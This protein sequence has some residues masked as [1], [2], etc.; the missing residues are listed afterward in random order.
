MER[1]RGRYIAPRIP[2]NSGSSSGLIV[3]LV[4]CL[5]SVLVVLG[6]YGAAEGSDNN[7]TGV[8]TLQELFEGKITLEDVFSNIEKGGDT[9]VPCQGSWSNWGACSEPC[10]GGTRSRTWTTT[11][12]PLYGGAACPSPLTQE[13][14]CNTGA[15][16]AE[17]CKGS[18]S[19]WSACSAPCG[20]GIKTRTWTTS[21][22][23]EPKHGGTACPSP[24]IESDDCNT[25]ACPID[26][27]GEW[28]LSSNQCDFECGP[29][30]G[31]YVYEVKTSA[32]HGGANCP[33]ATG[34][35]E[36]RDCENPACPTVDTTETIDG[37]EYEVKY[38]DPR[39]GDTAYYAWY[40]HTPYMIGGSIWGG[41][42][43]TDEAWS[44]S[45][46]PIR[47][48]DGHGYLR[49]DKM[50]T[51]GK[52]SYY[53][54]KRSKTPI[55]NPG[56]CVINKAFQYS[57]K[58]QGYDNYECEGRCA[59]KGS[60]GTCENN[61]DRCDYVK[62]GRSHFYTG[63]RKSSSLAGACKWLEEGET[64][65]IEPRWET[66]W[67]FW[68]PK[69]VSGTFLKHVTGQ[70]RKDPLPAQ[71]GLWDEDPGYDVSESRNRTAGICSGA[72]FDDPECTGFNTIF[73]S[74]GEG[75]K[76]ELFTGDLVF[77]GSGSSWTGAR[78]N[79]IVRRY[80]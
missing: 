51:S 20:G 64:Q 49:G 80:E 56:T 74:G 52:R 36:M 23:G 1:G 2:E 71:A 12:E 32:A 22:G 44:S 5:C 79:K 59:G 45:N 19:G 33:N 35:T 63:N 8:E 26:C 46:D 66:V 42:G 68:T 54:V 40:E 43:Q 39:S 9:S 3:L 11:A 72:C 41:I 16:P 17:P 28:K 69:K 57:M 29:Q 70:D 37:V 78:G 30:Q 38:Y 73:P 77:S 34:D 65:E 61:R 76:C 18:W 60:E 14:A 53:V 62:T 21:P 4:L 13:E 48:W 6:I 7:K 67:D 24:K 47:S 50:G 58:K 75:N 31:Q 27:V 10:G 15:C 25:Q 55:I